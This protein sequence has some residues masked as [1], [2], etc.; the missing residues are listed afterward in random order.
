M[1]RAGEARVLLLQLEQIK[2]TMHIKRALVDT[3]ALSRDDSITS[4]AWTP[5]GN[6]LVGT[7]AGALFIAHGAAPP[8]GPVYSSWGHNPPVTLR[9][10][11]SR[12][13]SQ[14]AAAGAV[15]SI[16]LTNHHV[17]LTFA[18]PDGGGALALWL[19]AEEPHLAAHV[20]LPTGAVVACALSPNR[21]KLAVWDAWS[22]CL[23]VTTGGTPEDYLEVVSEASHSG[24]V[25]STGVVKGTTLTNCNLVASLDEHGCLCLWSMQCNVRAPDDELL[26]KVELLH[27]CRLGERAAALCLHPHFAVAA[28]ATES[29]VVQ[30][31]D[32]GELVVAQP[33]NP[34]SADNVV[35]FSARLLPGGDAKLLQWSPDGKM[36]VAVDCSSGSIMFLVRQP[37]RLKAA[38]VGLQLLGTVRTPQVDNV[39]WHLDTKD[40]ASPA[41]LVAHLAQGQFLVL[42]APQG[43]TMAADGVFPEDILRAT[44]YRLTAPVNDFCVLADASSATA[45]TVLALTKDKSLRR[46]TLPCESSAASCKKGG[47]LSG[48]GFTPMAPVDAEMPQVGFHLDLCLL[49]YLNG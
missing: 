9:P 6:V 41:R 36:L 10:L 3:S 18:C 32:A 45:V 15:V 28:V 14:W 46:Y 19:Q 33:N 27:A 29:G 2:D 21:K 12:E 34:L 11:F 5:S 4:H 17:I 40:M 24:R 20:D 35:S 38:S 25:V 8:A 43:P 47:V 42:R 22:R 1:D 23:V 44:R 39:Q 16:V 26:P 49:W 37:H 30:L 13:L 48:A 7:Q 31:L